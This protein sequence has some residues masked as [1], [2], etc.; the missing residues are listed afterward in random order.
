MKNKYEDWSVV[1]HFPSEDVYPN[2]FNGY[3]SKLDENVR[4]FR[5]KADALIFAHEKAGKYSY[6]VFPTKMTITIE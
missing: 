1:F 3:Q 5:H 4:T 6:N 2:K